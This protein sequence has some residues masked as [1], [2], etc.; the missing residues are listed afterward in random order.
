[1][2]EWSDV[3]L[4][5]SDQMEFFI[6][7]PDKMYAAVLNKTTRE[8]EIYLITNESADDGREV[9][10]IAYD[11]DGS[12]V[13]SSDLAAYIRE[14]N[15]TNDD[16]RIE[17]V[18]YTT[19]KV[20]R[21][22]NEKLISDLLTGEAPDM[23]LFGS[24]ITPEK[25]VRQG[26]LIDMYSLMGGDYK[27]SDFLPCVRT[28]FEN[29]KGEL[30]Y[31]VT[32]YI[33]ETMIGKS[34]NFNGKKSWTFDEMLKMNASLKKDQTLMSLTMRD[35]DSVPLTLLE[36][37]LPNMLGKFIDYEK[38]TCNF[39][40][41]FK[42]LLEFCKT[43]K[44]AALNGY[45]SPS[46]YHD[47]EVLL[48]TSSYA[49]QTFLANHHVNF[50]GDYTYI[51]YPEAN[52][53]VV[54]ARTTFGI[55]K[56][57]DVAEGAWEFIEL[58]LDEQTEKWKDAKSRTSF[59][60]VSALTFPATYAAFD[61]M[62][63][64]LSQYTHFFNFGMVEGDG[65]LLEQGKYSMTSMI[66]PAADDEAGQKQLA[67]TKLKFALA[68]TV[69]EEDVKA[70]YSLVEGI[71]TAY[72]SDPAAMN[73]ILEDANDYFIGRK[74]LDEVVKLIRNRVGILVSE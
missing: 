63:E 70:L 74:S 8:W 56:R 28:P 2:F 71:T 50:A 31:L 46:Y 66:T 19:D 57:S 60:Y 44:V 23:I 43:A 49:L 1:L 15:A 36:T 40:E 34:S 33:I 54:K 16:Y 25:F 62:V 5:R 45:I 29:D 3:G 67:D 42:K 55:T 24:S 9:I 26:L 35:G 6:F 37:L 53:S 65:K 52:G 22:A 73:I 21:T 51:G 72:M 20:G 64:N 61:A 11:A 12:G 17:F 13:K 39:G 30:P 48:N 4:T 32:D 47:N 69:T 59:D 14:F 68:Y 10:R 27:K 58:Y 18:E 38:E 41:D 7:S